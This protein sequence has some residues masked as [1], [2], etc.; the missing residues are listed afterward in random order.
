MA[1]APL[2]MRPRG[3]PTELTPGGQVLAEY[4]VKNAVAGLLLSK[5]GANIAM[6][7]RRA[8]VR[9]QVMRPETPGQAWRTLF[10]Q[11]PN[12]R[13]LNLAKTELSKLGVVLLPPANALQPAGNGVA[14]AP[15]ADAATTPLQTT[16]LN[17]SD[18]LPSPS[19]EGASLDGRRDS[20]RR[21]APR[22][23]AER[24]PEPKPS[25]VLGPDRAASTSRGAPPA[26]TTSS[27]RSTVMEALLSGSWEGLSQFQREQLEKAFAGR[28]PP[29]S[30]STKNEAA[31]A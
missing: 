19:P 23:E 12:L 20:S 14:A 31:T 7:Q 9:L 4:E 2:A 30:A 24:A 21:S 3:N 16:T 26:A 10:V 13:S 8:K 15:A 25:P 1:D 22:P 28:G 11:G 17:P 27:S 5:K 29:S 18:V 6:I